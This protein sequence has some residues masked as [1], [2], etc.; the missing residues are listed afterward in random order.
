M[1][2]A[3]AKY[4]FDTAKDEILKFLE[5]H[6]ELQQYIRNKP[7]INRAELKKACDVKDGKVYVGELELPNV[8][9]IPKTDAFG[10]R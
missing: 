9:Y 3:P 2:S 1:Y 10:I 5:D 8:G 4:D 7:E 6:A